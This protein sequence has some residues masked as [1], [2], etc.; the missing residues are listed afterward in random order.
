MFMEKKCVLV[1]DTYGGL[2]R[3]VV[4]SLLDNEFVVF[5]TN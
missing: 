3:A 1:T 5:A 2:G 4:N